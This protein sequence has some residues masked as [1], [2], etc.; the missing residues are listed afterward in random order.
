MKSLELLANIAEILTATVAALAYGL[1]R[2]DQRSKRIRLENYLR[3]E[4]QR[5][6][7]KHTH[8]ILHV[9]AEVALTENEIL[10]AAFGS[11][12][13]ERLVHQN[14]DTGLA[15]DILLRYQD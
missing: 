8:T 5:N 3:N 6:P 15:D 2:Y 12:H 10:R 13:I 1:Y 4:K 7:A 11:R 14:Q 9:M